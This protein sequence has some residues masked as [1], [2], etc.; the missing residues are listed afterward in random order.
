MQGP[1]GIERKGQIEVGKANTRGNDREQEA[2]PSAYD[3][4]SQCV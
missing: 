1:N 4:V 2:K 3:D